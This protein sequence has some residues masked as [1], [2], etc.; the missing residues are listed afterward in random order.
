MRKAKI[1][2][3]TSE[4]EIS[5]EMNLDGSGDYRIST[6]IPFLDHMLALFSRHGLFDMVLEGKGDTRVDYHHL[7]EDIG[8]CL[9][10]AV[11]KA[12]G[13][14]EGITRYGSAVIPMDESLCGVSIDLSGRSCLVF[15]MEFEPQ[16]IGDFDPEL[17]K[18][19]LKAFVDNG[20]IT[21][22]VNLLY[23][24]NNHH[25]AE[26]MFKAFARALNVAVAGDSRIKGVLSTK[27][28]L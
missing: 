26:A 9:G 14:K 2:R 22:H 11:K 1:D 8:I 3:K 15:N 5:L 17:I 28:S 16:K 4:T 20:E 7:V 12:L 10:K 27:G 25:R 19:F 21:L 23:G 6:S 24:N 18:E 13:T